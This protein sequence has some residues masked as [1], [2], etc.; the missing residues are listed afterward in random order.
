MKFRNVVIACDSSGVGK[1]NKTL[2]VRW[3]FDMTVAN[4]QKNRKR[5]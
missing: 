2:I 4:V 3:I 5:S 1:V